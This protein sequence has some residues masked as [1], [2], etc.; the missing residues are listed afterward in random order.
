MVHFYDFCSLWYYNYWEERFPIEPV[1]TVV[2]MLSCAW[3]FA[4]A[5]TAAH[6]TSLSSTISQSLLKFMT[7]ELVMPPTISSSVAPFSSCPQSFPSSGS[8]LMSWLF[9]SSGQ[10]IGA[11]AS[12]SVLPMY[13]QGWS[14][15]GL[16]G[17]WLSLIFF[18]SLHGNK[19]DFYSN[20]MNILVK[21][22]KYAQFFWSKL[23]LDILQLTAILLFT[24]ASLMF[25]TL[26]C[27]LGEM[28][29]IFI[30][31]FSLWFLYSWT[32]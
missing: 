12:T 10:S 20:C 25:Q 29:L 19:G 27:W 17:L 13:I 28:P 9:A 16:T 31:L 3:L 5:W 23:L 4:T 21:M 1:T 15:F 32:H 14:P 22:Y 26:N 24:Y 30:C 11:S 8:F 7:I 2:Q 6:Q 18:L